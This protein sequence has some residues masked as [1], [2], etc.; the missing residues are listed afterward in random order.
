MSGAT[1]EILFIGLI[2]FAKAD[3]GAL[4]FL[5]NPGLDAARHY[6]LVIQTKGICH[7]EK[8]N[9]CKW[10]LEG[11]NCLSGN[12][13]DALNALEELKRLVWEPSRWTLSLENVVDD[14]LDLKYVKERPPSGNP[15]PETEGNLGWLPWLDD[16]NIWPAPLRRACWEGLDNCPAWSRFYLATGSLG[17]CHFAH[18][19]CSQ[20]KEDQCLDHFDVGGSRVGALGDVMRYV[21]PLREG[22]PADP[23]KCPR[24]IGRDD[25]EEWI[26]AR[27]IPEA[28]VIRLVVFN[29]PFPCG[30]ANK[31]FANGSHFKFFF[32]MLSGPWDSFG[33]NQPDLQPDD[34]ESDF[35]GSCEDTLVD[36]AKKLMDKPMFLP[37]LADYLTVPP[38]FGTECKEVGIR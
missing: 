1:L 21:V 3:D 12:D 26:E 5:T 7:D 11:H 20:K 17:V 18:G 29:E 22:C 8:N 23:E 15:T 27:L 25:W 37:G 35:F 13:G 16:H 34:V 36:L 9:H 38:H 4:M 30:K 31:L 6:P 14:G 32:R 10:G 24:L 19:P 28:G 2:A 33:G